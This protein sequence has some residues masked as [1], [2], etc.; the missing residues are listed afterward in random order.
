MIKEVEQFRWNGRSQN[1]QV[2]ISTADGNN[3]LVSYGKV[4]AAKGV[5]G[6]CL[7][8]YWNYSCTTSKFV[9]R[10]LGCENAKEVKEGIKSGRYKLVDEL[11]IS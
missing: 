2:V 6:V 11:I 10:F 8:R 5:D 9:A 7:S 3:Y 4:V 1:N